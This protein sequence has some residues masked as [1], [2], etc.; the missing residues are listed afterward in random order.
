MQLFKQ[1]PKPPKVPITGYF[2]VGDKKAQFWTNGARI[3]ELYFPEIV[4]ASSIGIYLKG[5]EPAGADKTGR[6]ITKY[7]EWWIVY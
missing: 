4:H 1:R 2:T 6:E 5:F 3:Y 7:Q